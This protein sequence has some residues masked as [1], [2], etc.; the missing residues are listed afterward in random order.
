MK[1]LGVEN[2]AKFD[3]MN[4]PPAQA[5]MRALETLFALNALNS[6][7][8]ITAQGKL[9]AEFPLEP[10]LAKCVITSPLYYCVPEILTIVAMLS[11]PSIFTRSSTSR[12][13][14]SQSNEEEYI[15][16]DEQQFYDQENDDLKLF[17]DPESD[18]ITLLNM[19]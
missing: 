16:D 19:Y 13:G 12:K 1:R 7:G 6:D 2:L 15:D 17:S 11:V 3:F 18:H 4:P 5:L 14:L 9:L 10:Q 8:A